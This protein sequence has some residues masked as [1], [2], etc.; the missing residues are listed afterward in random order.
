MYRL[1][2]RVIKH[3]KHSQTHEWMIYIWRI[4]CKFT[5]ATDEM[6]RFAE[7]ESDSCLRVDQV[8]PPKWLDARLGKYIVWRI[9]ECSLLELLRSTS[10]NKYQL[11]YCTDHWIQQLA[12]VA[13]KDRSHESPTHRQMYHHRFPTYWFASKRE[14]RAITLCLAT[15]HLPCWW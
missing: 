7:N 2:S 14:N 12:L 3:C 9:K 15:P 10:S 6:L 8:Y 11:V 5:E 4:S 13:L 1:Q